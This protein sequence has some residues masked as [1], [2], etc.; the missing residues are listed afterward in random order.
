[1]QKKHS[2]KKLYNLTGYDLFY[3]ATIQLLTE[4][5][6]K[7]SPELTAQDCIRSAITADAFR[8]GVTQADIDARAAELDAADAE[9]AGQ[10]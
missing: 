3:K 5:R 7:S 8:F 10:C 2:T 4:A 6:Q 9:K 1:M